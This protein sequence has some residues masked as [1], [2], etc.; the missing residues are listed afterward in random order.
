M[1]E[2]L[3]VAILAA[4]QAARFGGGK[5]DAPLEG[6]PIGQ[7]VLDAVLALRPAHCAIIVSKAAPAFAQ[8]AERA[9]L[10]DLVVN[11][12]AAEGIGT[13]VARAASWARETGARRLLI[14]LADMPLISTATLR[15]LVAAADMGAAAIAYPGG[16]AGI[17]A[18]FPPVWFERLQALDPDRGAGPLLSA[19]ADVTLIDV[20][21]AELRDIDT[22]SDLAAIR[23]G[24]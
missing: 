2:G 16:K 11:P 7:R 15:R 9:G 20:S 17:P 3:T 12:H 10:C 6:S 23:S 5:L 21:A 24:S 4:G 22:Q 19:S 13:S 8:R 18:C 1:S 14:V